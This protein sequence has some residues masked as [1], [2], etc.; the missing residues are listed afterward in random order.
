MENEDCISLI[1][2]PSTTLVTEVYSCDVSSAYNAVLGFSYELDKKFH[3]V[4]KD[5][6]TPSMCISISK[7]G[8]LRY[9][10]YASGN[11]GDII[12][13]VMFVER[14]TFAEAC[15]YIID[16]YSY[17]KRTAKPIVSTKR[18]WKFY[19]DWLDPA[20]WKFFY[21]YFNGYGVSSRVLQI[22]DIK[23]LFTV[24]GKSV[25][26]GIEDYVRIADYKVGRTYN[27]IIGNPMSEGSYQV[28]QPQAVR[29]EDKFRT[30]TPRPPL[31]KAGVTPYT[32]IFNKDVLDEKRF[33][34]STLYIVSSMKD[35]A[36]VMS[37]NRNSIA[38]LSESIPIS[39]HWMDKA[40]LLYEN[41]VVLFDNDETGI[42]MAN[43]FKATYPYVIVE[44]VPKLEGILP[45]GKL[46]KDPAD[47]AYSFSVGR[48]DRL[49][50][51]LISIENKL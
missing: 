47:L 9:T 18:T 51:V 23:P 14:K 17:T 38:G 3:S 36:C 30:P 2:P 31:L 41:I 46:T 37:R 35:V 45:D 49:L 10:C 26:N 34:N 4:F 50:E 13:L 24:R 43:R 21:A 48:V 16:K 1:N 42:K 32:P 27:L 25:Y 5:E 7:D 19:Y 15:R 33:K 6:N 8:K 12:D 44:S 39:K 11:H 29:K 22:L 20:A 40:L 28:Y